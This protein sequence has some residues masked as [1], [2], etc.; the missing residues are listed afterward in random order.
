M[1]SYKNIIYLILLLVASHLLTACDGA[2]ARKAKY[3]EKGKAYIQEKNYDK[4]KVE[5]K[6]VIQID[7]KYAEAYYLMGTV[8]EAEQSYMTA[9]RLKP[10]D[11]VT[12]NNLKKLRSLMQQKAN[13]GET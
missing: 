13:K 9:L 8:A 5:L 12:Q 10:D 4:A 1:E 2:D 7:P 3:L 6:N 11:S